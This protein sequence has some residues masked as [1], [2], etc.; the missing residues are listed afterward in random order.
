MRRRRLNEAKTQYDRVWDTAREVVE[1]LQDCPL[2]PSDIEYRLNVIEEAIQDNMH[3]QNDDAVYRIAL[4]LDG[5]RDLANL[6]RK[7]A[8]EVYFV[9]D[10]ITSA[11][12]M[13]FNF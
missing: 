4:R 5:D 11:L 3:G 7:Y 13:S 9:Y 12:S 1:Y 10:E 2:S 8:R 6:V